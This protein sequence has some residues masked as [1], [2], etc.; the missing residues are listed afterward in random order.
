MGQEKSCGAVV[1]RRSKEG[2]K[3]LIL[4]YEAK[5][6]D[7]PNGKLEWNE[8]EE[9]A[10]KREIKEETGIDDMQFSE[11]FKQTI[12]YFYRKND[13]VIHKEVVVFLAETKT[14][15]VKLS[16]EHIGYVWMGYEN[17]YKKLTFNNSKELLKKADGFL[18]KNP[19]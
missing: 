15:E 9:E 10:A 7:F 16:F 19:K 8:T 1:F 6:W 17:A 13:E 2:I 18:G 12:S 3:S 14:E 5:H 11:G 4:H